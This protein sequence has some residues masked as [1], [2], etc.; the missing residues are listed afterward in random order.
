MKSRS[1]SLDL[2]VVVPIYNEEENIPVL[3][4]R[5]TDALAPTNIDY[6][7]ILVDDGSSDDSYAAL[8]LLA[9]KD[10]RVK[11]VRFRRNFGQTAAMA[12][13]FD[14]ASGRRGDPHG[15]RPAERPARHPAAARPHRRGVRRGL[16]LAQGPEGHLHQPQAPLHHRQ[17]ASSPA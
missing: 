14:C 11:V 2:S 1:T 15:R 3:Y 4:Q 10:T 7:L 12:A 9:A 8:K 13:G 17:L 6:E 5:V 16:R